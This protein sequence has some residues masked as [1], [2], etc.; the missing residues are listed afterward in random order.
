MTTKSK[1]VAQCSTYSTLLCLI[2]SEVQVVVDVFIVVTFFVIDC[3]RYNVIFYRQYASNSFYTSGCTQQVSSH[4]LGRTDVQ[5]V[6]MFAKQILDGFYFRN[7]AYR[8]RSSVYVDIVDIFRF[9]SSIFQS[10]LHNQFRTQTFRMR[11]C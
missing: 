2:E 3:R 5:F 9:H 11:G 6:S 8:S 1:C 10:A 7:V 4:R